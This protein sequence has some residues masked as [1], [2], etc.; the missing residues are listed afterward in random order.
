MKKIVH[1]S[2]YY[3][4]N[5]GG[6]EQVAYDIVTG[7]KNE[8]DQKVIC[9]NHTK[10]TVIDEYEHVEIYRIGYA[11][12]LFRQA[13]S[14]TY[15]F[16]LKKLIN[17]YKPD[18]IHVHLPNPLITIYLLMIKTNAAIV[19]HWHT[20]IVGRRLLHFM[21]KPFQHQLIKKSTR[22][23]A[24]TNN[25]VDYS[26]YISPVKNKVVVFPY[27]INFK[28]LTVTRDV[29][30]KITFLRSQ[31]KD[32]DIL[33][34]VGRHVSY[35]GLEYLLNAIDSIKSNVRIIIAGNGPLTEN[36]KIKSS[37]Y[38]FVS[39][40]GKISD[41]EL[42]AYL[43][44]AKVFVFPSITK[45]EAFGIAMAEALHFGVPAVCFNIYGSGVSWVNQNNQ[46]GFVVEN[47]NS[48]QLADAI[49]TLLTDNDTYRTFSNN[50]RNWADEQFSMERF[51]NNIKELYTSVLDKKGEC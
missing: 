26:P 39:F 44:I 35:K 27:A 5:Y 40:I 25:H 15:Y 51:V 21:Y 32:E 3:L 28:K 4:P 17:T 14:F 1:I 42:I 8:Y 45:N 31:W 33:F 13:F 46:T 24:A 2:T 49:N 19:L 48:S 37:R 11:F 23:I 43:N 22:I 10:K 12:K 6:I 36:L 16:Y 18:I 38:P 20:D 41:L 34:F 47:K 50:A 30:E 9:F 29:T 7:L